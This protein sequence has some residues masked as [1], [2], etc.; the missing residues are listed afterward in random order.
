MVMKNAVI[1]SVSLST[2]S[3]EPMSKRTTPKNAPI[4]PQIPVKRR[5]AKKHLVRRI[6]AA[7]RGGNKQRVTA[8]A[9]AELDTEESGMRISRGFTIMIGFHVVAIG[10]IFFHLTFLR[11]HTAAPAA[12]PPA[13]A[14]AKPRTQSGAPLIAPNDR[15]CKVRAGDT[16]ERIATREGVNVDELRAANGDC[17]LSADLTLIL[18]QKRHTAGYPP[19]IEALRNPPTQPVPPR[20]ELVDAEPANSEGILVRPKVIRETINSP[21]ATPVA[22]GRSYVVK[23]GDS[24]GRI[25]KRLKVDQAALMRANGISDPNK[26][27]AGMTLTLPK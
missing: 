25:S 6:F 9:D 2:N 21:R 12:T 23:S 17:S 27:K 10:L 24:L 4:F 8:S 22:A 11:D 7:I 20:A 19:S 15:T 18:P 3:A 1:F 14:A 26:L 5:P 16:Y 13:A